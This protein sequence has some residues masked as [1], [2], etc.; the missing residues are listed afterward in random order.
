[1]CSVLPE[2]LGKAHGVPEVNYVTIRYV[3]ATERNLAHNLWEGLGEC[4]YMYVM[5]SLMICTAHPI[6]CG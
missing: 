3:S 6:L 2:L 4:I 1:M 5:R